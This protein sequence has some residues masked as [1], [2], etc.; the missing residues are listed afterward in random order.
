ME[1]PEYGV[2]S[3]SGSTPLK[4]A[5]L[6]FEYKQHQG[7]PQHFSLVYADNQ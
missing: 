2:Y 3:S 4:E 7:S 6:T 1:P 5:E